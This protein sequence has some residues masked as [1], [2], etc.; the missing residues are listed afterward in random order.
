MET[1]NPI[2]YLFKRIYFW[3]ILVVIGGMMA[4]NIL[5]LVHHV[6]EKR[7][8][9]L[10]QIRVTRFQSFEVY[11]HLI[12][13]TSFLTLAVTGFALKFPDAG[14]VH[15]LVSLGMTE[16]VRSVI[17][18]VAAMGL[19]VTSLIQLGYFIL[20]KKG[21]RDFLSLLPNVD[22]VIHVWQ[23][24]RYNLGLSNEK[25]QFGRYDYGE[26][27]EYLALIWG[28]MVMGAT[29]FILWFPETFIGFLPIW[30]F[31]TSEVIHYF[32]AW[33]AILAIIVWH[34]FFVFVHPDNAP[35]NLTFLDGKITEENLKH[36]HPQEYERLKAEQ[37]Q[38][39]EKE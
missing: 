30:M 4:H 39:E 13:L 1:R 20:T 18:R 31:E 6:R 28:N 9:E 34:W 7:K 10:G 22:D 5:I 32:E 25:P 3:L 36:H 38:K 16:A 35:V 14:W 2:A 29:G 23:N 19:A 15:L 12:M 27:A 17:H 24:I 37:T 8:K 21:R 33:L 11:Q 26:K